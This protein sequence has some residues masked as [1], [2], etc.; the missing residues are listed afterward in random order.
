MFSTDHPAIAS[1]HVSIN[2]FHN[3][4]IDKFID[5]KRLEIW[6]INGDGISLE[7]FSNLLI[8]DDGF[9]GY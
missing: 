5:F 4:H 1:L 7:L 3:S 6:D 9:M 2:K 8:L